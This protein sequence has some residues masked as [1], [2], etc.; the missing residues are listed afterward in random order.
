MFVTKSC[1]GLTFGGLLV[2][3]KLYDNRLYNTRYKDTDMTMSDYECLHVYKETTMLNNYGH[4]T[5]YCRLVLI[6]CFITSAVK[7]AELSSTC[8]C[9]FSGLFRFWLHRSSCVLDEYNLIM[10][11]T[12]SSHFHLSSF[13]EFACVSLASF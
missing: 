10:H 12:K 1:K 2:V 4:A 8:M 7:I 6:E 13:F 9:V 5:L 11:V 3:L